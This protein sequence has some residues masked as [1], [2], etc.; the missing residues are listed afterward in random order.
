LGL[1]VFTGASGAIVVAARGQEQELVL[2]YAVA[3][4]VAFLFGLLAMTKFAIR[5]HT[6][7]FLILTLAGLV[8]VGV[9]LAVNMARIYPLASLAAALLIAFALRRLWIRAGCPAGASQAEELA[10]LHP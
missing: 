4:F 1:A 8:A 7:R 6:P 9:T 2:F 3:V 5:E 10:E